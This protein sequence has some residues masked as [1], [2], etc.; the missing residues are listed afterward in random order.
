MEEAYSEAVGL[1]GEI[2]KDMSPEEFFGTISKFIESLSVN[3]FM[4]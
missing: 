2:P 3:I 1:F 4:T